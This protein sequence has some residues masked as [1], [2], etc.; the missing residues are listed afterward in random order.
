MALA[1]TACFMFHVCIHSETPPGRCSHM[2]HGPSGD[3]AWVCACVCVCVSH[4]C[5]RACVCD[6]RVCVHASGRNRSVS[7]LVE[8]GAQLAIEN[9][10]GR[11]GWA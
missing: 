3:D 2:L 4:V 11:V 6:L 9:I 7:V 10:D 8:F 1:Y 5:A